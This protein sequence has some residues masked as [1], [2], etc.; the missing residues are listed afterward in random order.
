VPTV[1][2]T[3]QIAYG[4]MSPFTGVVEP[5]TVTVFLRARNEPAAGVSE[6][7]A[8]AFSAA[9][10]ELADAPTWVPFT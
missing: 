7:A 3:G 10:A 1:C 4:L 6:V 2:V 5:S 9:Y 8:A